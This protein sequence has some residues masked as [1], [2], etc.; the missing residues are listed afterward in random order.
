MKRSV[1]EARALIDET[2]TPAATVVHGPWSVGIVGLVAARLAEDFGRPA[3]VGAEI[4]DT[5]RAS[6]RSDG[7]LDLGRGAGSLR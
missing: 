6:C 4:G 5:I 3:V 2:A 7:S 1:S